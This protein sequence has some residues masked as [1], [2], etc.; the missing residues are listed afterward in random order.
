MSGVDEPR[1]FRRIHQK[2]GNKAMPG[3][4]KPLSKQNVISI[5]IVLS[6]AAILVVLAVFQYHWTGQVS[7]AER[8]RMQASLATSTN[9]FRQE[10]NAELQQLALLFQPDRA[11]LAS[12]DWQSY[13]QSCVALLQGR[14][15]AGSRPLPLACR[16]H[17]EP[18]TPEAEPE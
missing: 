16:Q 10:F 9:Q 17:R 12:K 13:A 14:T 3:Q 6:L 11:V 5:G 4:W 18:A 15:G 1:R 8:E 7:Q 2:V